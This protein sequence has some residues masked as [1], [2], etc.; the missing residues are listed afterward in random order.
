MGWCESKPDC[1][2]FALNPAGW[3]FPKRKGTGFNV[4]TARWIDHK[5]PNEAWQWYYVTERADI[6][7]E[8]APSTWLR[9]DAL[10]Q[11]EGEALPVNLNEPR[12]LTDMKQWCEANVEC[13]GFS[14]PPGTSYFFPKKKGTGFD[15]RTAV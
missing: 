12:G 13:V 5:V 7:D 3:F 10:P 9:K 8:I 14:F 11:E 15:E 1:V 6:P 4:R 2:G